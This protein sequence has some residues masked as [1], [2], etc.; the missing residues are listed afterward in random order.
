MKKNIGKTDRIIR[1]LV[2]A[3]IVVLL[4]AD[5]ISGT[6]GLILLILAAVLILT[7]FFNFCPLYKLFG[8]STWS[9]KE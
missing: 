9:E 5:I 6:L 4:F 8:I 3:V 7:S 1:L 2:A